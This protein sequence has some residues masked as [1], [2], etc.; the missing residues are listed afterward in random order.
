[1]VNA[2]GRVVCTDYCLVEIALVRDVRIAR[3]EYYSILGS[4]C[5]R[6]E[7]VTKQACGESGCERK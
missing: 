7:S 1:M 5:W 3:D 4:A 6:N 2:N